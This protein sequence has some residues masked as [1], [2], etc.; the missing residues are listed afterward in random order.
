MY[1]TVI[2]TRIKSVANKFPRLLNPF[3]ALDANELKGKFRTS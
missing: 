2:I 1:L 3:E